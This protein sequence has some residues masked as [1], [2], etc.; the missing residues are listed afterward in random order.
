M[1][2]EIFEM[3]MKEARSRRGDSLTM[4]IMMVLFELTDKTCDA[5]RTIKV[6]DI[7]ST[8]LKFRRK[9]P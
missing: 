2:D 1:I 3:M 9:E 5:I 8:R 4:D 7:K 6:E